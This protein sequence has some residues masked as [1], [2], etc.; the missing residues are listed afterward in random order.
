MQPKQIFGIIIGVL[1][2]IVLLQNTQVVSFRFLFWQWSM[3]RVILFP[4]VLAVG[5]L[6]GFIIG[7]S[8]WDW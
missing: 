3:S 6:I 7:K 8:S 2:I 5:I 4:L 1:L